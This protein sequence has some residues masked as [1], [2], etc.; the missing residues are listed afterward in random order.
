MLTHERIWKAVDLLAARNGLSASG[1][2][3][4]AGLDP[5]SFNKSKRVSS[6]GRLRWPS[7]ESIAKILESTSTDL[8][9][10]MAL[11]L[12]DRPPA[13]TRA[14]PLIAMSDWAEAFDA[15]GRPQG[16]KWDEVGFPELPAG[17]LFALEL[18]DARMMPIYREGD[19][20][21]C[22]TTIPVR[23]GD[24]V[25]LKLKSG[26]LLAGTLR[27]KTMAGLDLMPF[28][29]NATSETPIAVQDKAWIARILWA[30]Q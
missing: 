21:I 15:E 28:G 2:A 4:R 6:D 16:P 3:R 30:S 20:L 10:F 7:T 23:R 24:R 18:T 29:A 5:T 13:P 9:V 19:I 17:D 27:R 26:E 1:L 25:I 11:V 12:A 14:I 8:E 22:A